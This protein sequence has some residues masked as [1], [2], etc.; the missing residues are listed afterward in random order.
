MSYR[1]PCCA[2]PPLLYLYT[3]RIDS[4]L[5]MYL[6]VPPFPLRWNEIAR[7][8]QTTVHTSDTSNDPPAG[9]TTNVSLFSVV[10]ELCAVSLPPSRFP[11]LGRIKRPRH[12]V[13]QYIVR[14]IVFKTPYRDRIRNCSACRVSESLHQGQCVSVHPPFSIFCSDSAVTRCFFLRSLE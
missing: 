9:T 2:H 8:P 6:P 14:Q 5:G 11:R 10:S 3:A 7:E 12:D 1:P 4:Q 13:A